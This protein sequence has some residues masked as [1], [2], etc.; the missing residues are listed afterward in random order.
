MNVEIITKED[1]QKFK[2]ELLNDIKSIMADRPKEKAGWLRSSEIM[3]QLK[4]SAGTLQNLRISGKLKYA[5]IGGILF[6]QQSDIEKLL[7]T[8]D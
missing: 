6:Y 1:L 2:V 5:R 3:A 4:I 7:N 8:N